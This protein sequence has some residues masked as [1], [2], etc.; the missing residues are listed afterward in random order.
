MSKKQ[1]RKRLE[2]TYFAM[3]I[4]LRYKHR[5]S[6]VIVRPLR[7]GVG[8]CQC[9]NAAIKEV[10]H[11]N[12]VCRRPCQ[13]YST[14]VIKIQ[15]CQGIREHKYQRCVAQRRTVLSNCRGCVISFHS[16]FPRMMRLRGCGDGNSWCSRCRDIQ[17]LLILCSGIVL[18]T[19]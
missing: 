10:D 18:R 14:S 5:R 7:L 15:T 19:T 9:C 16:I 17:S 8:L 4:V 13:R 2:R 6:P 1:E 3:N 11:G 12:V